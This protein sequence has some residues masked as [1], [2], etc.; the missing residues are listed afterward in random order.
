MSWRT[1]YEGIHEN[2]Y[3]QLRADGK[4]SWSDRKHTREMAESV[5]DALGRSD[6]GYTGRFLELGCG[7][8]N[9]VLALPDEGIERYGIDIS[10]SA[11]AMANENAQRAGLEAS[12]RIGDVLDLPF[13]DGHFE[14]VLDGHCFHCIIGEDRKRF[15]SEAFRV[16]KPG[17]LLVVMTM[18]NDPIDPEIQKYFDRESRNV[19]RGGIAGRHLG[20]PEQIVDEVRQAGFEVLHWHVEPSDA[21]DLQDDLIV[22]ARRPAVR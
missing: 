6:S 16:L 7:A 18:C 11:I 13:D 12:F 21:E 8:G 1:D 19:I 3:K 5:E 4:R 15:L 20:I 2:R 22:E 14:T 9:L 17:G 10:E